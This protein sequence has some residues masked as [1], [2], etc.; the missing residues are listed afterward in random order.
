MGRPPNFS[1]CGPLCSSAQSAR[2]AIRQLFARQYADQ[3]APVIH[4]A[5]RANALQHR[6]ENCHSE[7]GLRASATCHVAVELNRPLRDDSTAARNARLQGHVAEHRWEAGSLRGRVRE[8]RRAV[9][10]RVAGL[11]ACVSSKMHSTE[12]HRQAPTKAWATPFMDIND[13]LIDQRGRDWSQLLSGWA[14]TIPESFSLWLVNRFGDAF[15]VLDDESVHLLDVGTGEFNRLADDRDHFAQ[16]LDVGHNA[17]L[18]LLIP[19]VDACRAALPELSEGQCYGFKVPRLLGGKY[20]RDNVA[21]TD[22]TLH[23]S[24]LSDVHRQTKDLPD[25]TKV[26]VI[27]AP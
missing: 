6:D 23:Y 10:H 8:D 22:L 5:H 3:S 12:D 7:D 17:D 4:G 21:P 19:L 20:V 1:T 15:L 16:L 24:V 25:G 9:E 2:L 18:W 11:P 26:R 27:R 14:G 13:Y